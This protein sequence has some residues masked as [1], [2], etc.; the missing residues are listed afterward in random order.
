[1]KETGAPEMKYESGVHG[2]TLDEDL[3]IQKA[4][5]NLRIMTET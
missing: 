3:S 1:M 4:E 2:L 5:R